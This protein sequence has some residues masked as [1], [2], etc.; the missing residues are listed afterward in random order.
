MFLWTTTVVQLCFILE[1]SC[2]WSWWAP[3][4]EVIFLA[5]LTFFSHHYNCSALCW[6]NAFLPCLDVRKRSIKVFFT[7]WNWCRFLWF[8]NQVNFGKALALLCISIVAMPLSSVLQHVFTIVAL[9]NC[10]TSQSV[11]EQQLKVW[12]RYHIVLP[13]KLI[14][15]SSSVPQNRRSSAPILELDPILVAF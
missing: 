7:L 9:Q 6:P 13:L 14:V 4:Q 11:A 1:Q 5:V 2:G 12:R 8:N 3:T 10:G 15:A